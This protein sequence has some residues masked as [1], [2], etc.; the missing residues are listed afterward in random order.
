VEG[1]FPVSDKACDVV[2]A[3]VK[4]VK[5]FAKIVSSFNVKSAKQ[6]DNGIFC[7][8]GNFMCMRET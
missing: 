5:K 4:T 7:I 1:Y 2:N 8:S 3:L 6:Y